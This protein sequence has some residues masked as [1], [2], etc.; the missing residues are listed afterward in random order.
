MIICG[1]FH[2]P[3]SLFRYVNK[4]TKLTN[5]QTSKTLLRKN[6]ENTILVKNVREESLERI[7]PVFYEKNS[8]FHCLF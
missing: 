1:D 3:G 2:D 7:R 5:F 6:F 8:L 4:Q